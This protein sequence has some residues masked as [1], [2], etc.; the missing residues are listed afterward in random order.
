MM[1]VCAFAGKEFM[2]NAYN[3]AV[4]QNYRFFSYGDS[5][6]IQNLACSDQPLSE[7]KHL[8]RCKN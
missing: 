3:A 7:T 1:L 6:F 8:A 2:L 4:A 5:M